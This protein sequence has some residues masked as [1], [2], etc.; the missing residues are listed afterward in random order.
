VSLPVKNRFDPSF[1]V[2]EKGDKPSQLFRDYM[3]KLDALVT[4]IAL[5]SSAGGNVSQLQNIGASTTL[6]N[7]DTAAAGLGIP[8]GGLYRDSVGVVHMRTA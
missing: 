8:V 4:A 1:G 7:N 6:V 2:T 5:A 3:A